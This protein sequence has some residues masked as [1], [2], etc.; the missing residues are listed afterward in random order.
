MFQEAIQ[1]YKEEEEEEDDDDGMC[2]V[3]NSGFLLPTEIYRSLYPYQLDGILWF[4]KL[5]QKGMGGIL[6]DDM[7]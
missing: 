6:G 2:E 4:W 5:Y 7:G 3:G 1:R